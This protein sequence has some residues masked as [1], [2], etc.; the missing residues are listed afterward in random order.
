MK[1]INV[2]HTSI[3]GKETES[4]MGLEDFV[5]FM[6]EGIN[7]QRRTNVVLTAMNFLSWGLVIFYFFWK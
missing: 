1:K 6:G 4:Q 5:T 3:L 2:K 7:L